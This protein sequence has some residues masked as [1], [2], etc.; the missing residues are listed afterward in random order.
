MSGTH[1]IS[2]QSGFVSPT[3]NTEFH[4]KLAQNALHSPPLSF[5]YFRAY[6]SSF[7]KSRQP[8]RREPRWVI[9]SQ[10]LWVN[11][12]RDR[13]GSESGEDN[14]QTQ[15]TALPTRTRQWYSKSYLSHLQSPRCSHKEN[16]I[17]F[18]ILLKNKAKIDHMTIIIYNY[19]R[20]RVPTCWLLLALLDEELSWGRY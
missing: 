14:K 4:V 13:K 7:K 12:K 10:L 9:C 17:H 15:H 19:I 5:C 6:K 3:I 1:K 11:N 2:V 8:Q 20:V 18:K 16:S